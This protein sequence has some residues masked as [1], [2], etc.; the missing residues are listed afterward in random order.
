MLL[1]KTKEVEYNKT[2]DY[3]YMINKV[4]EDYHNYFSASDYLKRRYDFCL[5]AI[6][7]CLSKVNSDINR[8][9]AYK[10]LYNFLESIKKCN[11]LN[12]KIVNEEDK[13]SVKEKPKI[14]AKRRVF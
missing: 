5:Q 12:M 7:S 8:S 11:G 13:L 2:G 4:T 14:K 1:Y 6:Y 10:E 9:S 3:N